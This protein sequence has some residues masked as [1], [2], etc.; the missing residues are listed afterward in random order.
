[1]SIKQMDFEKERDVLDKM[2]DIRDGRRT[3]VFRGQSQLTHRLSSSFAREYD[4]S[5]FDL[6]QYKAVE[7]LN[8]YKVALLR[9]GISPFQSDSILD[10]MEYAR[11][12]ALPTPSIDFTYSPYIGLFFAYDDLRESRLKTPKT[13]DR[14]AVYALNLQLLADQ[15]ALFPSNPIAGPAPWWLPVLAASPKIFPLKRE[16]SIADPGTFPGI[17]EDIVLKIQG[18]LSP[19]LERFKK[20][21]PLRVLQVVPFPGSKTERI[22]RQQGLLIY[23][24]LHYKKGKNFEDLLDACPDEDGMPVAY[25]LTLPVARAGEVWR[26]LS[27]MG[28]SP[29]SMYLD[30]TAA[31][32]DAMQQYY[33]STY[34]NFLR[35]DQRFEALDDFEP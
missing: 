4:Q 27:E 12:Y 15:L 25:K 26:M 31:V 17:A 16:H 21:L 10:W 7:L 35:D 13:D 19:D 18:F 33:Y 28:I 3:F 30:S 11:H 5:N 23:D 34:T 6:L 20:T 9:A 32:R 29:S 22:L 2:S 14:V 8:N 24:T 1:M